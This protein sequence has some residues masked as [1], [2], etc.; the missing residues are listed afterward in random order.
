MLAETMTRLEMSWKKLLRAEK[1]PRQVERNR[2]KRGPQERKRTVGNEMVGQGVR[3]GVRCRPPMSSVEER[4][5]LKHATTY[6]AVNGVAMPRLFF[7]WV[8]F[9]TR[10]IALPF[11]PPRH[12]H[13]ADLSRVWPPAFTSLFPSTYASRTDI[14]Q[15]PFFSPAAAH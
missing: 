11:S 6:Q 2:V 3:K 13:P 9:T 5:S 12:R 14:L 15:T 8:D 4:Q 1:G 10:D 7:T